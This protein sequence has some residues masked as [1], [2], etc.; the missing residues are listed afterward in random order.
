MNGSPCSS[1]LYL[2]TPSSL[3]HLKHS[4][5]TLYQS[6]SMLLP[7]LDPLE[8]EQVHP[9]CNR[10]GLQAVQQVHSTAKVAPVVPWGAGRS[11]LVVVD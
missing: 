3:R 6:L 4:S 5:S 9:E 7:L 2:Q 10:I 8:V 1:Q 11:I